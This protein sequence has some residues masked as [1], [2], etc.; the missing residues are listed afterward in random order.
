M[1]W[2]I[3]GGLAKYFHIDSTIVRVITVLS[4]FLNGLGIL[5]YIILAIVVLAASLG[6]AIW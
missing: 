2:G 4:I 3:C 1:I 5:A 6:I